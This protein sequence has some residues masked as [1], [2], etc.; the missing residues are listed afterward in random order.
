MRLHHFLVFALALLG[1]P[2]YAQDARQQ[3]AELTD[4]FYEQRIDA[5]WQRMTPQMQAALKSRE[6]LSDFRQQL[7]E[8]LGAEV[9]LVEEKVGNADGFR[10]YQRRARFEKVPMLILVQWS[11]DEQGMVGGFFIRPDQ[12]AAQPA[13]PSEHLDYQTRTSLRLPFEDEFYVFWGGRSVEQNYHA[14][15]RNQRF[16]LDLLIVRDGVSHT[17]GGSRNDNYYCFGRPILAPAA[18]KVVEAIDGITDNEPGQ[19]N[20]KEV[21]GNRVIIDHGNDEYSVLAHLRNGSLRVGK[22][23]AVQAGDRLGDC[24]NSGNSSEPHLHYQLQDGPAFDASAGLPAQFSNY[25]ADNQ[26]VVRGEPTRGQRIR[27]TTQL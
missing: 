8:Q 10:I 6:G 12:N 19:M 20:P 5:I 1:A 18:G 9:A 15:H 17:G 3:G 16:A 11:I 7:G 24:G 14:T 27:P 13:A 4:A 25:S 2:A 21:T 26:P 22:G 23:D